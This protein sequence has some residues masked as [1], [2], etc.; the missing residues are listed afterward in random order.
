M[1]DRASV[2]FSFEQTDPHLK[3]I[4]PNRLTFVDPLFVKLEFNVILN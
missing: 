4:T 1:G 2:I 3:L